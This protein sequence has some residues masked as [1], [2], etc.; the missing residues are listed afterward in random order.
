[1]IIEMSKKRTLTAVALIVILA[2]AVH[3]QEA[4][5][6]TPSD[7]DLAKQLANPLASL[8]SVPMQLNY[9]KDIGPDDDGS[10]WQLNIQ[11]VIPFSLNEDWLLISRTIISLIDQ[12]DI[13]T[14]GD[15]DF[16]LGDILQSFFFSP[17]ESTKR[18][19]I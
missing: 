17:S 2:L 4:S 19:W 6:A 3:A 1:M 18:G 15:G 7:E 10:L 16:G 11:P 14:K 5:G 13:P 8:I 9:D 12:D